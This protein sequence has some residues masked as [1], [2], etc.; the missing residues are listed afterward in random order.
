MKY[1]CPYF[2]NETIKIQ[3]NNLLWSSQVAKQ[4]QVWL[5]SQCALTASVRPPS[6]IYTASTTLW[7]VTHRHRRLHALSE[8]RSMCALQIALSKAQAWGFVYFPPPVVKIVM[9]CHNRLTQKWGPFGN[10]RSKN[11]PEELIIK[12]TQGSIRTLRW[13]I[14]R[15]LRGHKPSRQSYICINSMRDG[16]SL[17]IYCIMSEIMYI[18]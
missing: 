6:G 13:A 9:F 4:A 16:Y 11:Y 5:H 3:R 10:K 12:I 15:R 8:T 17:H 2:T 14:S 1:D 7:D 18:I